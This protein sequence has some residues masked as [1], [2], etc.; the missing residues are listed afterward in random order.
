MTNLHQIQ[1]TLLFWVVSVAAASA[2]EWPQFRG[3]GGQGHSAARNLPLEWNEESGIDWKTDLP[4]VGWSSPVVSGKRIFLTTAVATNDE[5]IGRPG[6]GETKHSRSFSLRTLCLDARSGKILWNLE[7]SRVPPGVSIHLKNSHA[8]PTPVT[9]NDRVYVHFG[10]WGTAALDLDGKV[11]WQRRL[12]YKPVH[13]SGGS[14]VLFKDML[15]LNCDG[16]ESPFVV[17]M[18]TDTGDECWRTARPEG[19]TKAF[20]FSTPLVIDVD[21]TPQLV[22]AGSEFVCAYNPRS[23]EQLWTVRYPNRFSVVPR[24]VYAGGLVLVCTGYEGPAEL[25]AI[26]PDGEGDVTESHV[27]WRAPKYVPQN[28]SPVVSNDRVYCVS[29]N[30]IASCRDLQTGTLH[31]KHRLRG[32]FSSSP[33]LAESRIW[34]LSEAGVCTVIE[35]SVDY[36][37]LAVNEIDEQS[38]ASLAPVNGA[39]F[40]RTKRHLYRIGRP[41]S[42]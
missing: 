8:S 15:I 22:S 2:D 6:S 30:G 14:P 19:V 25:I 28:P 13:G 41:E 26:R 33:I 42:Q 39:L 27:V 16:A 18:E 21:G 17:A 12:E 36:T 10:T 32:D 24:P 3:P 37:R 35:D 31:W 38:L 20:S 4:G 7:T 29:D 5:D 40:I 34:F 23:G 11:I 1:T 9:R